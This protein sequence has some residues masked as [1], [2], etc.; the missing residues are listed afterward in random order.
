MEIVNIGFVYDRCEIYMEIVNI[1]F[2]CDRCEI[3]IEIVN[4]GFVCFGTVTYV[5]WSLCKNVD[6]TCKIEFLESNN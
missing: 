4:I 5:L 1:G 2:V 6:L 3:Y